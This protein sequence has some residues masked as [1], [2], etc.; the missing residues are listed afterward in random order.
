[1]RGSSAAA[2]EPPLIPACCSCRAG[3][4]GLGGLGGGRGGGHA[5]LTPTSCRFTALG[6]GLFQLLQLLRAVGE[7]R[8]KVTYEQDPL[9]S[10][11]PL[12]E[13]RLQEQLTCLL[14]R[15]GAQRKEGGLRMG[16]SCSETPPPSSACS[17]FVVEQ[18]PCMPN[19]PKRPLV[20]RTANKFCTRARLL[21]RLHDRNHRMEANIHIDRSGGVR[22]PPPPPPLGVLGHAHS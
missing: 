11:L 8:Q 5:L 14:Q 18:Q 13:K 12:L 3:R 4:G 10:E 19:T 22:V 2:W 6:E 7:L 16:W 20:L 1:M 15:W 9:Q 21:V 17:A